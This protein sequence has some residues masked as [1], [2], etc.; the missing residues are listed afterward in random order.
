[1]LMLNDAEAR[2]LT[3]RHD[4]RQCAERILAWGPAYVVIKKGEHGALL[5]TRRGIAL[6]PAYPVQSL[7]DPT[8]AGDC[9]AGGFAGALARAGRVTARTVR[10]AMLYGSVVASFGVEDF[11]LGRLQTLTRRDI[12]ERRRELRR[13]AAAG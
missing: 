3:R 2:L 1:M 5:F 6:I 8:G 12:E 7:R 11:S 4:L 10:A 9:F 13:M